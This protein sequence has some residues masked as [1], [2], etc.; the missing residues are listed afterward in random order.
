MILT[1]RNSSSEHL[2][3]SFS[4]FVTGQLLQEL[5]SNCY[6]YVLPSEIEG[7]SPGLLEAMSYRNCVLVSDIP[8]NLEAIDDC[9]VVFRS[10]NVQDLER[11]L[12]YLLESEGHAL[13]LRA[14]VG[15][16]VREK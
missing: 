9:G 11:Q 15:A 6:V 12:R 14:R 8:E 13:D 10:G 4:W 2:R 3:I 5:I 16:H 7:L 1:L